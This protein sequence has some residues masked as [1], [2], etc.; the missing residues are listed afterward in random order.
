MMLVGVPYVIPKVIAEVF[1]MSVV[2]TSL[3]TAWAAV[4]LIEAWM[5]PDL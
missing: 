5:V 1:P 2:V 3:M 4:E